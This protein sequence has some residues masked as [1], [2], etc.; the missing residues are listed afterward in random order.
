MSSP[1]PIVR[2]S[3]P[4]MTA[5]IAGLT[6]LALVLV[7][8]I[9]GGIWRYAFFAIPAIVAVYYLNEYRKL[10]Y[11]PYQFFPQRPAPVAVS[12]P[13]L[14]ASVTASPEEDF[15][16]PVEEA[17]RIAAKGGTPAPAE[18]SAPAESSPP[19]PGD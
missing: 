13:T 11:E 15:E 10:P 17:D 3:L 14:T 2:L 5:V 4:L 1:S 16:D 7:V 18:D 6:L 8:E 12:S 19:A 9:H